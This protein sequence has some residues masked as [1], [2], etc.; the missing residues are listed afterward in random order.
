MGN[1]KISQHY[2]NTTMAICL[3]KVARDEL[4]KE[5]RPNTVNRY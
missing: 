1:T 3:G 2:T 5:V 4:F